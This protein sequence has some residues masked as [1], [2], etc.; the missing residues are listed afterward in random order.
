MGGNA[1]ANNK[2]MSD[3]INDICKAEDEKFAQ[4]VQGNA[5]EADYQKHNKDVLNQFQTIKN[6]KGK[7]DLDN[8]NR[9]AKNFQAIKDV[10]RQK[11]FSPDELKELELRFLI[12]SSNGIMSIRSF[13]KVLGLESVA[14]TA[15]GKMF[16]KAA[17]NFNDNR[18]PN[19]LQF[20]TCDK[21]LQIVAVFTKKKSLNDNASEFFTGGK[22][23]LEEDFY[24]KVRYQFLYTLF[25][26]D[27][28][29][30]LN[31]ID[32]RNLISSF[33]EMVI[34]GKFNNQDID[35]EISKIRSAEGNG[36]TNIAQIMEDVL[37]SYVENV[38]SDS[39]SGETLTFEDWKKWIDSKILGLGKVMDSSL[40]K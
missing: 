26:V 15:F 25:D 34:N 38:F 19:Q 9:R 10:L 36:V 18:N 21:F 3:L 27:N 4:R 35:K 30:E 2:K 7:N 11:I 22:V 28:N 13:W 16:Y 40:D 39:F 24:Q 17:C 31:K 8:S 1:D 14:D 12:N 6:E 5:N 20:M 23:E 32:F 33:L 37:D 29:E